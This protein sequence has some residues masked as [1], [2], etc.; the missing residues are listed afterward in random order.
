MVNP[1]SGRLGR[2]ISGLNPGYGAWA[3]A[4]GI[5]STGLA[6]YGEHAPSEVL[7]VIACA[8]FALLLVAYT[9]RIVGYWPQALAGARNPSRAF[10]YFSLV[11]ATNVVAV[12]LALAHHS[13]ATLVLGAASVPLWLILTYA[14]PGAMFELAPRSSVDLV[15]PDKFAR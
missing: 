14:I 3:M 5:M 7:L 2:E 10:G 15:L 13:P 4:T 12:R 8:A 1:R 11:A 9:W 6:L